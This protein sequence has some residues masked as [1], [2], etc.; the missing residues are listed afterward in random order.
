MEMT[1]ASSIRAGAAA[2]LVALLIPSGGAS[3]QGAS[4]DAAMLKWTV[5]HAIPI[6][7]V[8]TPGDL[9][10]LRP[11][12]A[13]IGSARVVALGEPTHGAHEPLAFRNRLLRYLVEERGFTA[14]ALET[15]L[16]ESRRLADFAA[17]A[18][19]APPLDSA[20][21]IVHRGMT[22]G[23]GNFAENVELVRWVRTYNADATH[24]RKVRVYGMDLSLGGPMGSTPMP[25]AIDG[26]LAYLTRVDA[27]AAQRIRARLAPYMRAL[28]GDGSS[29][30]T[31]VEHD[32]LTA[33][34]EELVAQL[35]RGRS[36][37]VAATSDIDYAWARRNAE[38]ARQGDVLFRIEIAPGPGGSIPA[39]AWRVMSARDSAMAENVR[40][41]LEREGPAGRVLVFAHDMHVKNAPT[42]G[43]VWSV[44]ER[45]PT[46]MGQHLR[47]ALGAQL[48]I[49]GATDG[50][51]PAPNADSTSIDALLGRVGISRFI[52]DL[53]AARA[54][55]SARAWLAR[56]R[57]LRMNRE[58]FIT[59]APATA[60]DALFYAGPLTTARNSP[61]R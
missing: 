2:A 55:P 19:D 3:A 1:L 60:F 36:A 59:L 50:S 44:L 52:V 22:W 16:P 46:A 15:G 17:G 47:A 32:S 31:R 5:A 25:A 43:G 8:E 61:A 38:I 53:R 35:E 27:P 13:V 42:V 57:R 33:G 20:P 56:E 58:T 12:G 7:S 29:P 39:G 18:A 45:P 48:V 28:P 26:A 54:D 34:I 40:W 51:P 14:I 9:A 30:L 6:S 49:I 23:F 37:Y 24:R 4:D 11:L 41:V 21:T 10:D